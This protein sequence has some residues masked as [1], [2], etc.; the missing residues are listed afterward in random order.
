M[1]QDN[2]DAIMTRQATPDSRA[3]VLNAQVDKILSDKSY[4]RPMSEIG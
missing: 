2:I 1:N 3:A 4:L